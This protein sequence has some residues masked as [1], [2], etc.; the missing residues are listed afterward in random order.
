M[1]FAQCACGGLVTAR[2]QYA[3][4]ACGA[5][6]TQSVETLLLKDL[7]LCFRSLGLDSFERSGFLFPWEDNFS[8]LFES[9]IFLLVLS[10]SYWLKVLEL[11]NFN[12]LLITARTSEVWPIFMLYENVRA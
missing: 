8:P 11:C 6:V 12:A 3:Q 9:L 10:I 7:L 2:Q 1:H 4:C 5:F